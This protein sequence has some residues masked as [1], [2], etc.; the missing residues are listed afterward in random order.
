MVRIPESFGVCQ[1][2]ARQKLSSHAVRHSMVTQNKGALV[3][4][5]LLQVLTIQ[6]IRLSH[7]IKAL[8][9]VDLRRLYLGPIQ[10][11]LKLIK[12]KNGLV[13]SPLT[14]QILSIKLWLGL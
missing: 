1:I 8:P 10:T 5:V 13:I 12:P 14:R 11:L 9:L 7:I 2:F 6:E 4:I 3:Y